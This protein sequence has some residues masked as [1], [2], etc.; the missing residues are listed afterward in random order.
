MHRLLLEQEL[1]LALEPE[2]DHMGVGG[3]TLE[4]MAGMLVVVLDTQLALAVV[5]NLLVVGMFLEGMYQ[6][7]GVHRSSLLL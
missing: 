3:N 1:E 7:E 6:E 4:D 5:R 2:Q